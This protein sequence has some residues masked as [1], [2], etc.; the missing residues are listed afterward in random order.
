MRINNTTSKRAFIL[1]MPL[2][3]AVS[4][5][6]LAYAYF[7]NGVRFH[8]MD[9]LVLLIVPI[10]TLFAV[11]IN[12]KH[13]FVYGKTTKITA[14]WQLRAIRFFMRLELYFFCSPIYMSTLRL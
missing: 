1:M 2:C 14:I 13:C 9:I 4:I 8:P 7:T 6:I 11:I 5:Y 3:Y 10:M 12:D